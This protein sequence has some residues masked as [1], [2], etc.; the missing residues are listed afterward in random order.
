[1]T[2]CT[3][4]SCAL[5]F[6]DIS[7]WWRT[8]PQNRTQLS[9]LWKKD[10]LLISVCDLF[11]LVFYNKDW[12]IKKQDLGNFKTTHTHWICSHSFKMKLFCDLATCNLKFESRTLSSVA[13]ISLTDLDSQNTMM[14]RIGWIMDWTVQQMAVGCVH[15]CKKTA[16]YCQAQVPSPVV[17]VQSKTSQ[18]SKSNWD[19][20][21]SII[22]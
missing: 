21:D 5:T 13:V 12:L 22:T 11:E 15:T 17:L 6:I 7:P 20:G 4:D 2:H 10:K 19:W 14:G 8:G 18:K 9:Y 1:M 16:F 3:E